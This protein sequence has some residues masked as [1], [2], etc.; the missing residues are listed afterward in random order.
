MAILHGGWALWVLGF[1]HWHTFT[2]FKPF[3][4]LVVLWLLWQGC[5]A[6]QLWHCMGR[7]ANLLAVPSPSDTALASYRQEPHQTQQNPH[8]AA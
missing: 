1:I 4:P 2:L 7:M 8:L 5:R 3:I 6:A